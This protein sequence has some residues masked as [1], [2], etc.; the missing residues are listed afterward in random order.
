M[1]NRTLKRGFTL[2]ELMITI[3]L[4]LSMVALIVPIFQISTKTVTAVERRL[5]IYAATR[6]ILDILDAELRLATIN[7][8]GEHFSIKK[9]AYMDADPFTPAGNNKFF[10]SRR[11]AD[12]VNY[13]NMNPG[14]Y[15]WQANST[16][17]L[18]GSYA[19]PLAYGEIDSFNPEG[20]QV[21]M[22]S[23]LAYQQCQE[24]E[25]WT[26]PSRATQLA[27]V[28][29]I[30][31]SS[32]FYSTNALWTNTNNTPRINMHLDRYPNQNAPGNEIRVGRPFNTNVGQQNMRRIEGI[33]LMDFDIAYW[34]DTAQQFLNVPDSR[35][36]YFA[37]PP[38][39]MRVT[40]TVCDYQKQG[41]VTL[42]R[43]VWLPV[44]LGTGTVTASDDTYYVT[45]T[46]ATNL[47]Q[48]DGLTQPSNAFNRTKKMSQ[49]PES[50]TR[51]KEADIINNNGADLPIGWP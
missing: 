50:P 14:A 16:T 4:A 44:G 45:G 41:Q 5:T 9:F 24:Y 35:V 22:R 34:D 23:T 40:V 29:E 10:E 1:R 42:S 11:E 38:K 30:A 28:G 7:E 32:I 36:V 37:P 31:S 21:S 15:R 8:R 51:Y 13:M 2:I 25:T 3:A 48:Y 6:N 18:P 20:W 49:L 27:D 17:R 19:F 46:T 43:V 12:A 39:A 33:R 47:I 26:L